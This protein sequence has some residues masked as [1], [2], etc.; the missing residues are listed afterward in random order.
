MKTTIN[1]HFVQY[2]KNKL[3]AAF[4]DDLKGLVV[5]G[6]TFEEMNTNA[7]ANIEKFVYTMT[8]L[9]HVASPVMREDLLKGDAFTY[10]VAQYEVAPAE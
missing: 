10:L 4:S 5:Q 3:L 2:N 1:L 6:I 9:R 8:G 7:K